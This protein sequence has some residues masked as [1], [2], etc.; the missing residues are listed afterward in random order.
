MFE[1]FNKI[2]RCSRQW[3]PCA[4]FFTVCL[5]ALLMSSCERTDPHTAPTLEGSTTTHRPGDTREPE[6]VTHAETAAT[7]TPS[8]EVTPSPPPEP[9]RAMLEQGVGL[10]QRT[11]LEAKIDAILFDRDRERSERFAA[12][13]EL[14]KGV[15]YVERYRVN[16]PVISVKLEDG[17]DITITLA[18]ELPSKPPRQVDW[19]NIKRFDENG[20]RIRRSSLPRDP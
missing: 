17:G 5:S 2:P 11:D 12:I 8:E 18:A 19:K 6:V 3:P 7:P 13:H 4:L 10:S 9:G 1:T 20:R 14:L 16:D 15:P